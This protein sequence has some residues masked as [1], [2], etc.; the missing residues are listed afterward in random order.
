MSD[1]IANKAHEMAVEAKQ[2]VAKVDQK[3]ESHEVL[4]ALRYTNINETMTRIENYQKSQ[5]K[6]GIT[7]GIAL[8]ISLIGY[9]WSQNDSRIENIESYHVGE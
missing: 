4:C 6:L 2:D 7:L 3:V 1:D 9:A 8:I 5:T